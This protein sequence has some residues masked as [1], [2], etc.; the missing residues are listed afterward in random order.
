V[1]ERMI[2]DI[3]VVVVDEIGEVTFAHDVMFPGVVEMSKKETTAR[4]F[5]AV[6]ELIS[7]AST[8]VP[9][10]DSQFKLQQALELLLAHRAFLE[11]R[12]TEQVEFQDSLDEAAGSGRLLEGNVY[13]KRRK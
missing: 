10:S 12:F 2:G 4:C 11:E 3:F 8:L 6:I 5:A 13:R 9:V 7:L 1:N